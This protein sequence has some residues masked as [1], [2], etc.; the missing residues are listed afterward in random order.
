VKHALRSVQLWGETVKLSHSVFALPFALVAAFL[1]GRHRIEDGGWPGMGQLLLL[2]LCMAAARSTAMTFNRIVDAA[3]DSRNPRTA[4]RPIPSGRLKRTAAWFML[5]LS[6]MT[7]GVGCLGFHV[8]YQN[9]W[10]M[11]LSG[12][13]LIYLCGYSFTKRFTKWS[14]VYLGSA[15]GLSPLAAWV[16]VHPPS[17]GVTC[18]ILAATVTCWIAGFDIIYACQ[19]IEVDRRDRLHSLPSRLGPRMALMVTRILHVLTVAGLITVGFEERLGWMY[20]VGVTIVCVALL[21]ENLM[22]GPGRYER[23][24]TAFF[25]CNGI[26]SLVLAAAVITDLVLQS[27]RPTG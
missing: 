14:H 3:I 27:S 8:I 7:F 25:T 18:L 23:V 17:I 20:G 19:D 11:L 5:G 1:A 6:A 12:P 4:N 21:V 24:N 2:I 10:P 22:V 26:V 13:V 16:A 15:I 9:T